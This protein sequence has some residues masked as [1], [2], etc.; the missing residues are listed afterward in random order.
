MAD[1]NKN[2]AYDLSRF[3]PAEVTTAP[4]RKEVKQPVKPEI[5]KEQI[6]TKRQLRLEK[7]HRQQKMRRVVFVC[8]SLLM[9]AG[10][11]LSGDV[12]ISQLDKQLKQETASLETAQSEG[13]R[14]STE[15]EKQYSF[16]KLQIYT[17]LHGMQK[18]E[19]YQMFYFNTAA[20]DKVVNY[21]GKPAK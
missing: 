2:A 13:V 7:Q 3:A 6:A 20:Q 21:L 14:L 17:K 5:V 12:K 10:L 18:S 8:V 1:Y 11:K 9:A 19:S 15:I 4:G 16:D